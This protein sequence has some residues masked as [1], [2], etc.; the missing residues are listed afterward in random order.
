VVKF[1]LHVS[2]DEQR[3]RFLDRLDDPTKHWKFS[4]ADLAER[5]HF[6]EYQTAYEKALGATSTKYA[7]WYVIPADHKP[8]MRAL[9]AGVIVDA[10]DGLDLGAP[11]PAATAEELAEARAQLL[12]EGS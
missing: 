3:R 8:T 6:A 12:A 7:P 2:K 9:V 1:F 5:A 11:R 4:S 10:I